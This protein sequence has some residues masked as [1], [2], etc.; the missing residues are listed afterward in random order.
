[1]TNQVTPVDQ[2]RRGEHIG[3][4]LDIP[5]TTCHAVDVQDQVGQFVGRIKTAALR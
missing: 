4:A 5:T 1:M 2:E 3:L